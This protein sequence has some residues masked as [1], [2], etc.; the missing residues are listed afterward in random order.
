MTQ[1]KLQSIEKILLLLTIVLLPFVTLP[2]RMIINTVGGNATNY[3]ILALCIV[4]AVEVFKFRPKIKSVFVKFFIIF[5]LARI[6]T[7]AIGLINYPYYDLI[8]ID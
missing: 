3:T 6:I 4:F 5:T 7:L 1:E 2:K 8:T